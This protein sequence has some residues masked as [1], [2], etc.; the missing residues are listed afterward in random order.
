MKS[1]FFLPNKL[2]EFGTQPFKR[3]GISIHKWFKEKIDFQELKKVATLKFL[4]AEEGC[5]YLSFI[6]NFI[7]IY[8]TDSAK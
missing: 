6:E 2:S 5:C 8:E 1:A 4:Q 3:S 7:I